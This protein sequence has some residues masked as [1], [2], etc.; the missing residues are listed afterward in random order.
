[1]QLCSVSMKILVPYTANRIDLN[2]YTTGGN[3]YWQ[4][5]WVDSD[6][7]AWNDDTTGT[8]TFSMK[9]ERPSVTYITDTW[10]AITHTVDATG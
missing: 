2:L 8:K 5:Q 6:G 9:H 3:V 7:E 4:T 1:M 10:G